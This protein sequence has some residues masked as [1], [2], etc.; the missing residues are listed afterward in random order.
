IVIANSPWSDAYQAVLAHTLSPG[1]PALS[2]SVL[3]WIND[4]L[5]AVFFLVVGLE[6][7]REAIEGELSSRARLALPVIAAIGG[8]VLPAILYV[9][10]ND[11]PIARRGWAIPTATDIAFSLAVLSL[12]GTRVPLALKVFLTAVAIVDDLGAIVVIA[13]FYTEQ[14]SPVMLAGGVLG[15]AVLAALNYANVRRLAPYL[16]FG[17]ATWACVLK[18]GVHATL[19]GV[20]TALA[21]PMAA[22]GGRNLGYALEQRLHPW[23]AFGILPL[24][25]LANAGVGLGNVS[26]DVLRESIPLGI[27]VGL[28][29]GKTLG[30]YGAT[31]LA[32]GTG[33]APRPHGASHAALL[34]IAAIGGI[35]FTMSLFIGSLAFELQEPRYYELVKL[36]VLA[37]SVASALLGC[38]LLAIALPRRQAHP[39]K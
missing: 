8:M 25:A 15:V 16:L 29:A 18:S 33:L 36:G 3:H 31:A 37:G 7:K 12:F 9:V 6:I 21:I 20:A 26:P 24:F 5:M 13:V 38:A 35:G 22:S 30:I 17:L 14:L 1:I 2:K 32:I 27:I 23:V 11:D 28:V 4:G 34:G 39:R 10:L 19:A